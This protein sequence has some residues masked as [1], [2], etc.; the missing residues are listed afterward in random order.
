MKP[1]TAPTPAEKPIIRHQNNFHFVRFVAASLVI[2]GHSYALT[3]RPDW[4]TDATLGLFPAANM[5]VCL[6]FI[7]SGYLITQSLETSPTTT[8]FVWKR[9]L[10]IY[11]GL[12]ISV[13]LTVLV[14][15]PLMTTLPVADY[16]RRG[17]TYRYLT[18][19]RLFPP[20]HFELPGVFRNQ[21]VTLVNGSLWTLCYEISF[22][23]ILLAVARLGGFTHRQWLLAA[24]GLG[25]VVMLVVGG[26]LDGTTRLIPLVNLDPFETLNFGLFFA[27]GT[28]GR[29]Y[30]QELVY[31]GRYALLALVLWL[32]TY[33]LTR[34]FPAV[35]LT[36]IRWVRY[37]ALSYL[38]LYVCFLKGSLNRFGDR[39]DVSYGLYI[40]GF[41][42]QQMLVSVFGV[43]INAPLM[44]VLSM[45]AT[46]PLAAASWI[47]VEKPAIKWKMLRT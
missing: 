29:L 28:L 43:G 2:F 40:Y 9:V 23:L 17:D 32:G 37:P 14:L 30:R 26:L 20:Y 35:P 34:L 46:L 16:F 31:A 21:P 44:I 8:N 7:V 1:L 10:R 18:A 24:T 39:G 5:G 38:V 15:G 6:F 19:L 25:W 33:V 47:W 22:Y 11:P 27:A 12:T 42:V 13:L 3:D 45:A 4:I 36:L 41:P